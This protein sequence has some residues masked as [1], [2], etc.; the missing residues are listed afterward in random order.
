MK[1]HLARRSAVILSAL[2]FILSLTLSHI[3]VRAQQH[4]DDSVMKGL[5]WRSIGPYRGGR[6]P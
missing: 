2:A 5:K 3:T 6:L 1:G 4:V